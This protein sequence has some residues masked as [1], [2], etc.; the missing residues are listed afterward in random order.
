MPEE[1][2]IE[3]TIPYVIMAPTRVKV[4]VRLPVEEGEEF[5]PSMAD[6][7][8]VQRENFQPDV[9]RQILFDDIERDGAWG[10][11]DNLILEAA[12]KEQS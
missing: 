8:G 4:T 2:T 5:D 1:T 6:I 9:D 7:T 10:E 3:V 11:W 12:E